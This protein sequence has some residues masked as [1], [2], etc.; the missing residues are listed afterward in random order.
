MELLKEANPKLFEQHQSYVMSF[1]S[2]WRYDDNLMSLLIA[3]ALFNPDRPN[4]SNH[5]MIRL[6]FVIDIC[7][8][9]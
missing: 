9:D 2:D 4:L 6:V 3:I 1:E 5:K 7:L 8:I